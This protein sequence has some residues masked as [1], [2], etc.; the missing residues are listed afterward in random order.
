MKAY[1]SEFLGT[2]CLVFC[3]TGAIVI[4]ETHAHAVTHTGVALSFGLIVMAMIY[5]FSETSGAHIN[6]A[7]T[8]AL[9]AAG[10]FPR[11]QILPYLVSQL[12]GALLASGVLH[13]LFPGSAT[14]GATLPHGS[15]WQSL[16]LEFF[17]TYLLML[18]IL[19]VSAGPASIRPLAGIVIGGVVLLEAQFAGPVS[20]ASMNPA[21]SLAP[22][23]VSGHLE[24]SWIYLLAPISGALA[25]VYTQLLLNTTA[26]EPPKKD[27]VRVH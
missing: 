22:A 1:T 13:A 15:P 25:A 2:F 12:A 6:P 20:G 24:Y 8:L 27:P 4:D 19:R 3:G 26:N 17:L 23:L 18:V 14:L 5:S 7:V 21:R 10:Q 9:G 11:R 16:I